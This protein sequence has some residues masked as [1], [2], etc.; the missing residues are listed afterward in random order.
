MPS[1]KGLFSS[2]SPSSS[3][4]SPRDSP[5]L[6]SELGS[7]KRLTRQRRLRYHTGVDLTVLTDQSRSLPVSPDS[8][9]RSLPNLSHWSVLAVPQPLPLPESTAAGLKQNDQS[10]LKSS[11]TP[12][13]S[14]SHQIIRNTTKNAATNSSKTPTYRR[15][16]IHKLL[17]VESVPYS[18]RLNAPPKSAPTTGFSSPA[19]SPQRFSTV[20]LSHSLVNPLE[21]RGSPSPQGPLSI[22][23]A[24]SP[25]QMFSTQVFSARLPCT[26][27]H[28]PVHSPKFNSAFQDSR[29]ASGLAFHSHHKSLPESSMGLREG[30]S[31]A[32]LHPLP[33]PPGGPKPSHSTTNGHV[34]EK[35][36][37]SLVK[38]QWTKGKL[39]G[40]GTFGSVYEAVNRETGALCAMKEVDVIGDDP[41]SAECIRQLEQEIKV[42]QNLKHSNIVQYYGCEVVEDR[43]CI[44]LEF[45]H[46]GSINK[47][48]RDHYGAVTES[49]VRNF[50]RHILSGLAY[51]HSTK[52]VHRDIKGANL[53]VDSSGVVKLADF[54]LAKHLTGAAIDLS[55]KGSP[56]WM[57]PEVLQAA[58]RK[59]SNP[60]LAY[61]VDIWSVG[62]TVIEMLDGKPP[63]SE[64]TPVQAMF[65]VLHKSPTIPETLSSE[66]KDFLQ[67]CF[68]RN[69]ADRPSAAWLLDHPF[70]QSSHVMDHSPRDKMK[71]MN[72]SVPTSPGAG[73]RQLPRNGETSPKPYPECSEKGEASRHSP[74]STLEALPSILSPELNCKS[75]F[76][77]QSANA[78]NS[79]QLAAREISPKAHRREI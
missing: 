31:H 22:K 65:N 21:F 1:L 18:L 62:C 39:I 49:V 47:Y 51:L 74:R 42:L 75:H 28:S 56:H 52:T 64:F 71:N 76:V 59:D 23:L 73:I 55:L 34:M 37:V 48:V 78:P 16:G 77:S 19:L 46:P 32:N 38:G 29:N 50:T 11:S 3:A 13:S 70:L 25:P 79:L 6:G 57:A 67:W 41:K 63:W 66:G 4:S 45:V 33:L 30:S 12:G 10:N 26:P 36:D 72:G 43:F 9:P 14:L 60:H 20:D 44:Y 27:D 53:L 61:A 7:K 15:R 5:P 35:P 17:N 54:G 58:M 2:S 40:R 8:G 68:R 24:C 69:P